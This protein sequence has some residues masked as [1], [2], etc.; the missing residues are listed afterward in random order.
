MDSPL[1]LVCLDSNLQIDGQPL[2]RVI[3]GV[4]LNICIKSDR[5]D[6]IYLISSGRFLFHN[7]VFAL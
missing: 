7:L 4:Y 5:I 1:W 6:N 2:S 3:D